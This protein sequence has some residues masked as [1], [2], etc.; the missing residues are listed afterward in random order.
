MF[1]YRVFGKIKRTTVKVLSLADDQSIDDFLFH[2]KRGST[3]GEG[4]HLYYSFSFPH[5][6]EVLCAFTSR[7]HD[8]GAVT[9][10]QVLPNE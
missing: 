8:S 2:T 6:G 5:E 1:A 9:R 7:L 10:S 3:I 4:I